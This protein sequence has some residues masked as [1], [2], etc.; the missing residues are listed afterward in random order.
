VDIVQRGVMTYLV[1]L[2]PVFDPAHF[3][4]PHD[5]VSVQLLSEEKAKAKRNGN[6]KRK[7]I[8]RDNGDD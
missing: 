2:L 4:T 6:G 1:D 7:D 8:D 5:L 3:K